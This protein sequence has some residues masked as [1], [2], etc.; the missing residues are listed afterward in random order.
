MILLKGYCK[1]IFFLIIV[2]GKRI[3]KILMFVRVRFWIK[4]FSLVWDFICCDI[5]K[6]ISKFFSNLIKVIVIFKI[7]YL[8]I[9]VLDLLKR[10]LFIVLELLMLLW[11]VLLILILFIVRVFYW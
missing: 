11:G 4:S 1:G 5:M 8:F 9:M 3:V 6:Y 10:F 2:I 7:K